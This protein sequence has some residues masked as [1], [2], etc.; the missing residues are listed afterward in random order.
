MIASATKLVQHRVDHSVEQTHAETGHESAKEINPKAAEDTGKGLYAHT[1]ETYSD[2][3]QSRLL[4]AFLLKEVTC[5]D[6]HHR[7]GNEVGKHTQSTLPVR[8][9]EL[10][11]QDVA[12]GGCQVGDK[13]N[14]TKQQ[15]HHDNRNRVVL[16]VCGFFHLIIS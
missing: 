12:H 15:D 6:A 14:H 7:I 5:R 11:L 4:V 13:R 3:H 9:I 2:S 10:V 16:F 8:D 1:Y